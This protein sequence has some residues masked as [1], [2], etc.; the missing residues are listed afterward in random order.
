M[1]EPVYIEPVYTCDF[2]SLVFLNILIV[3]LH[4]CKLY[5]I[6][7]RNL[8]TGYFEYYGI[9][10]ITVFSV[11]QD[12]LSRRKNEFKDYNSVTIVYDTL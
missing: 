11:F 4:L 8:L 10:Y 5:A 1:I 2:F 7:L 6:L 9:N 12:Y 3:K